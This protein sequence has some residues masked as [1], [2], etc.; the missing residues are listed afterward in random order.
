MHVTEGKHD[1][2]GLR[3]VL[4]S[5]REMRRVFE[6]LAEVLEYTNPFSLDNPS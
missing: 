6:A 5:D 2:A 4:Y 3:Q 1:K